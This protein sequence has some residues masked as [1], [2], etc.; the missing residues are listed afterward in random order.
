MIPQFFAVLSLTLL[1]Q[2][3]GL[4]SSQVRP[5][6]LFD[7]HETIQITIVADIQTL[8][9]DIGEDEGDNQ[10]TGQSEHYAV[11]S[12]RD[13]AGASATLRVTAET[14]GHFRRDRSNCDFPPLRLDFRKSEF[15]DEPRENSIFAGQNKLKMV[16]HCQ[17]DQEEFEQQLIQEYLLY[18][19]YNILSDKSFR[20]RLA[21]VTYVDTVQIDS[22]TR[23]AF[24]IE[25]ERKLAE[26]IGGESVETQG[27]H[28]LDLEYSSMATVAIFQYMIRNTDWSVQ[29]LHN[30]KIFGP[31]EGLLHPVP[32]DFDWSGVV[33]AP[34][35]EPD[36]SLD[37][38]SIRE[39]LYT[40]YCRS[41]AEFE[42]AFALFNRHQEAIY[43]L[44]RNQEGINQDRIDQMLQ[45]YDQFFFVINRP[46]HVERS[47]LRQCKRR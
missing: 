16:T 41:M 40:G 10:F 12:Y 33:N 26:R 39:P 1:P 24:I 20:V 5:G 37:I 45:D 38:E 35:A 3:A 27:I 2:Q 6:G 47:I 25:D 22:L 11:L 43:D 29:G 8:I 13:P 28:P 4:D 9:R 36:R 23:Y 21:L 44:H 15:E 19:T 32:F 14:R 46:L 31:I 18:R 34:Y 7:S 42:E 30:I 17:T